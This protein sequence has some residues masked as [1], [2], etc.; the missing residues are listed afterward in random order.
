MTNSFII[1]GI[2]G[3]ISQSIVWPI[4]YMKTIKQLP[5]HRNLSI[6]KTVKNDIKLNG[7]RSIYRGL[8]PQ[9][10]T[11]IPRAALRYS[12]FDQLKNSYS[13]D[14]LTNL[15]KLSFG[16]IAGGSE[17]IILTTSSEV[18]KV[19]LIHNKNDSITT[20][21]NFYKN[22]G[23]K[24]FYKGIIPTTLR[25]STNHGIT[26]LTVENLRPLINE[27]D[28]IN[29]YSSLFAGMIGGTLAV[30]LNN[31]IDVIK[32]YKQSDRLNDSTTKI[33][34]EIYQNKG[35]KGFYSGLALRFL[36]V[37]PMYG[38]TFFIYDSLTTYFE[39]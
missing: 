11:T 18:I 19:Q 26:F 13:N 31:P 27:I 21:K 9:L 25:Q 20:L 10:I 5:E 34:K 2:S 1:G 33:I 36:R 24:G 6:I 15:K 38:I 4:E 32:T 29:P 22:N 23:I 12:I 39:N 3:C 17:A 30:T 8:I 37:G 14:N 28:Y 16:M 35:I 7:L